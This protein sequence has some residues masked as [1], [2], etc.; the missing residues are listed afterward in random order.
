MANTPILFS[1][2]KIKNLSL[3]NRITMAPTY[4]GY[5]NP[6]GTVSELAL[7]HYKEMASSGAAMIVVEGASINPAGSGSPF[8]IRVDDDQCVDG[9]SK[10]AKVIKDQGAIAVQQINHAGKYAFS[11]EPLGPTGG[12]EGSPPKE[13]SLDDIEQTVE[14][15][16]SAASRV[17]AAG[18]DGVEIHGGTGYLIDQFI[19]PHTNKRTDDYGGSFEN[20][21]RFPLRVFEAVQSA[22]GKDFPIGHRFMAY[23][24]I[25]G[26]LE[27]KESSIWATEL[28][29]RGVAY[30]SV[31]FGTYESMMLPE[32]SEADKTEGFMASY[33]GE[34][35]KAVSDTP[36]I[37]AGRIQSPETAEKILDAG[38]ADLIGLARVLF[39]DPLWPQKA[40]GQI[41]EPVKRC[42]PACMLCM[43]R[44]MSGKP[45]FCSQWDKARREAFLVRVGE[46][47]EEV[48]QAAG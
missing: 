33:A 24:A 16:A 11:A 38:T 41:S 19:S 44:I 42:E 30:L 47:P 36:V 37:T 27:L 32:Y 22:V 31:M 26:G 10:L 8:A 40:A 28:E 34:I 3:K 29:K 17:K 6:D 39:A 25:P 18:F 4:V 9:L 21:L 5:A 45:A 13:M 14:A 2:I 20:R 7:D 43:K 23:E 35:K 48:D 46:K 12:S 1:S 15:F